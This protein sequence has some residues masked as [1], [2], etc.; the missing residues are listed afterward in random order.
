MIDAT[1]LARAVGV[2][3]ALATLKRAREVHV[4]S[5]M[6]QAATRPK[7]NFRIARSAEALE[8]ILI[9]ARSAWAL[10]ERSVGSVGGVAGPNV[11]IAMRSSRQL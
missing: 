5:A 6:E 3:L 8:R 2:A 9:S 4:P 11:V 7:E 10:V 1:A